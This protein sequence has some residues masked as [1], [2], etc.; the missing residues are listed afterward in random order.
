MGR[1]HHRYTLEIIR[2]DPDSGSAEQHHQAAGDSIHD[3]KPESCNVFFKE[4]C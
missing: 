3:D 1:K 2:S 4:R